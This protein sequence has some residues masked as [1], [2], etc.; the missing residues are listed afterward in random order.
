MTVYSRQ[1]LSSLCLAAANTDVGTRYPLW[2]ELLAKLAQGKTKAQKWIIF[3]EDVSQK[4]ARLHQQLD[5]RKVLGG[6]KE[7]NAVEDDT[8]FP[9][10]TGINI[11][12]Q[13]LT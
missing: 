11:N 1:E 8:L 3:R 9:K 10:R 13:V 4:L 6:N 5:S 2:A 7:T 12:P